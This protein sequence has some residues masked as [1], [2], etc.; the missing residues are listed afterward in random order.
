M[1]KDAE[2]I[3]REI[4]ESQGKKVIQRHDTGSDTFG[5]FK[6]DEKII[7]VKGFWTDED[8]ES[9][10]DYPSRL[11]EISGKE[12]E[13]L[14]KEPDN[15]ELWVVYRLDRN[16]STNKN[17]PAKYTVIPGPILL[18]ESKIQRISLRTP[19]QMWHGVEVKDIPSEIKKKFSLG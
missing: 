9:E 17:W 14:N 3:V 12:W 5:D 1:G 8:S 4:L 2:E 18:K 13:F 7:E 19:E 15:F 6:V 11:I 10:L 16:A